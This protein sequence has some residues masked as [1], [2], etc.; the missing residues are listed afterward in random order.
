MTL[1]PKLLRVRDAATY[2][3][4]AKSTLDKFRCRG[5]GPPFIKRGRAIYYSIE[6]LD[7]WLD[8]MP[9]FGSV[10]EADVAAKK[11]DEARPTAA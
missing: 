2:C 3:G 8:A 10:S 9:R 7:Q 4:F 11:R 6:D 5:G 1:T